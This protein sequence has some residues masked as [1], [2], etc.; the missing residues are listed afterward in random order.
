MAAKEKKERTGRFEDPDLIPIMNLVC[1]LI[2]LILWTT[3]W[4]AF[5]QITVMRGSSHT[6]APGPTE[7]TERLRLVAVLTRGSIT[8]L[9]DRAVAAAV[10]PEE[11]STGTKGRVDVPHRTLTLEE[12]RTARGTCQ[13][14]VD[15]GQFDDCAYWKYVERF[16]SIC[17]QDPPGAVKVPDFKAFNLALRGIKDRVLAQFPGKLD[18]ADQIN[19]K[20]ED[21]IPYCQV[22]AMMDFARLRSFDYDWTV[23]PEFREGVDE[24]LARGINDPFLHPKSWNDAMRRELLFPVVGFVN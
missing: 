11:A 3:T 4:L 5:G 15:A 21:D 23:D 1:L 22:V 9:A 20:G 6:P 14:A 18:D 8:L 13:P 16:V 17:Y 2:P 12:I 19:V 10:M 7:K 24:A